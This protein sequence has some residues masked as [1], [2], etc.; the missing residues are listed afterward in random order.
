MDHPRSEI[1]ETDEIRSL[2]N[3]FPHPALLLG[4]DRRIL[5][6]NEAYQMTFAGADR[7]VGRY[8]YEVHHREGEPCDAESTG[9]P[10]SDCSRTGQ[11]TRSL[12][13]H[14]GPRGEEHQ[15]VSVYP[16]I[17]SD[18][19]MRGF[20]TL[21]QRCHAASVSP[22]SE[23]LV[24][25][26]PAF[27]RMLELLQRVAPSDTPILLQG[28]PGTEQDLVAD[29]IHRSSSR[30]HG[31][32]V[33][34]ECVG[35]DD[36]LFDKELFGE[37]GEGQVDAARGGTLFLNELG[38]L[39]RVSQGKLLRLLET[40]TY[41]RSDSEA[42]VVLDFRLICGTYHNLSSLV[43]EDLFRPDL[44]QRI[45]AFPIVVPPLRE[46][47]DDLP[48][49][50]RSL[51][52]R[53]DRE[54][55]RELHATAMTQLRSYPFPGNVREL[56]HILERACLLAETDTIYPEHVLDDCQAS[57]RHPVVISPRG[58]ILSLAE[59]EQCYLQWVAA[60]FPGDRTALAS[61][62]GI[63]ERTL[64]RRLN[65]IRDGGRNRRTQQRDIPKDH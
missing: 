55:V 54:R 49:L 35:L 18:G 46:R 51:L 17:R 48:L 36:N 39:P 34:V 13:V 8:C 11:P 56:L 41:P 47:I 44:F 6:V 7:L 29:A 61:K 1:F 52:D 12:H 58:E 63:G 28:E 19:E 38:D 50:V 9:C 10:V 14:Y 15:Q 30:R 21:I 3:S 53:I 24:G 62:L 64:Y 37:P 43:D 40:G 26:S 16:I 25:R 45:S 57:P 33:R 23:G 32:M 60:R 42:A 31:P 59:V 22:D 20:L 5:S 2:I 27:T 4:C 65:E